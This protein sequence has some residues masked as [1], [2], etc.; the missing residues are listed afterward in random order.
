MDAWREYAACALEDAQTVWRYD[1]PHAAYSIL[2]SALYVLRNFT[3]PPGTEPPRKYPSKFL[4][5]TDR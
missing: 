5:V 2:T 3:E 1:S 4:V